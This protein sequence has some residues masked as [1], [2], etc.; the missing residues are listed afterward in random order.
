[1]L[2]FREHMLT[3]KKDH[4]IKKMPNLDNYQKELLI[5][6]FKKRTDLES[7]VDWNKWK[8]LTF[9]DFEPLLQNISK[10]GRKLAVKHK[11]VRGMKEGTDY[12][13][14]KMKNTDYLAYIPLTIEA[15]KLIGGKNIGNCESRW[16]IASNDAQHYWNDYVGTYE[17]VPIYLIGAARKWAIMVFE[18][19]KYNIWNWEDKPVADKDIPNFDIKKDLLSGKN[20]KVIE[21]AREKL[22]E[23]EK[24]VIDTADAEESYDDLVRAMDEAVDSYTSERDAA[25]SA[26]YDNLRRT[27]V[28]YREEV[29]EKEQER[30]VFDTERENLEQV[31]AEIDEARTYE[32][33]DSEEDEENDVNGYWEYEGKRYKSEGELND[34]YDSNEHRISEIDDAHNNLTYDIEG[35]ESDIEQLEGMEPHEIHEYES[36]FNWDEPYDVGD[37]YAWE[38]NIESPVWSNYNEYFDFADDHFGTYTNNLNS[39]EQDFYG[40]QRE[41]GYGNT[42]EGLLSDNSYY[43]PDV[44]NDE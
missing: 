3:E 38:Q 39:L 27:I 41:E 6:F 28:N 30:S 9:D 11:G 18:S 36:E 14:V 40:W 44:A 23:I 20:K 26:D 31:N 13:H 17:A 25:A 33:W 7:K 5:K 43:H 8:K 1:M 4:I 29:T 12:I 2:S 34:M 42:A 37:E 15:S 35:L 10:R 16:C 21:D 32:L 24:P 22:E 19:G